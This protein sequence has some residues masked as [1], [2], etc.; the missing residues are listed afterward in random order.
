MGEEL[1]RVKMRSERGSG[2]HK[3][4]AMQDREAWHGKRRGK[5]HGQ[6][7][8]GEWADQGKI[9]RKP[10]HTGNPAALPAA[11]GAGAVPTGYHVSSMPS[12]SS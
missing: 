3:H 4:K 10:E 7:A 12:V 8:R 11:E 6:W 1:L 5:R 2:S 9:L